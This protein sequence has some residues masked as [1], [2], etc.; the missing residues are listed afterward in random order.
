[1]L[2]LSEI[3][4]LPHKATSQGYNIIYCVVKERNLQGNSLKPTGFIS[5]AASD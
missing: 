2:L 3:Y 4:R 1:M 5:V